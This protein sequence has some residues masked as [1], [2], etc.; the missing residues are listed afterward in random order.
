MF[1][2]SWTVSQTES[3]NRR[4]KMEYFVVTQIYSKCVEMQIRLQAIILFNGVWLLFGLMRVQWQ[5]H[6]PGQKLS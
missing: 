3:G 6:G 2:S 4:T 5:V 1:F